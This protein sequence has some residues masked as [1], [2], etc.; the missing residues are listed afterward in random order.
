MND[1][2]QAPGWFKA[3]AIIALVWNLFGLLAF[4]MQMMITPEMIAQMPEEQ[5][6]MMNA[7]PGW[8]LAA[9]GVATI[10]GTLGSIMLLLK[11][12]LAGPL[13]M[14]SL[15]GVLVQ[16]YWSVVLMD[17]L[18]TFTTFQVIMTALVVVFGVY[19]ILLARKAKANGW[20]S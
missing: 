7:M 18:S 15:A 6:A 5:Q 2:T 10:G 1:T 16:D 3:I 11:K 17:G 12:N 14:L 9:M 8:V 4:G 19:L 20:T 13:F